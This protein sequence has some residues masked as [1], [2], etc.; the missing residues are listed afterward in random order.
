METLA[1]FTFQNY[2]YRY[3][4]T[5][6]SDWAVIER[7]Q[8]ERQMGCYEG[9]KARIEAEFMRWHSR[10]ATIAE[11]QHRLAYL[12]AKAANAWL[13]DSFGPPLDKS[14]CI[15]DGAGEN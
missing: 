9:P 15:G 6:S 14:D 1:E 12:R 10:A 5:P 3:R 11:K 4:P 7:W 13:H 2:V 8:G